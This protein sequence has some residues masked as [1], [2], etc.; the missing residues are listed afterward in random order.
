V[1]FIICIIIY[2]IPASINSQIIKGLWKGSFEVN[3]EVKKKVSINKYNF[4]V[5]INQINNKELIGVTYSY[6]T[7]EYS[8]KA[9]FNGDFNLVNKTATIRESI[10]SDVEKNDNS[11]VCKMV[12]VLKYSK[13]GNKELLTGVFTSFNQKNNKFCYA[14]K[15]YLEKVTETFFPKELFIKSLP[16][17]KTTQLSKNTIS[18]IVF[19]KIDKI[20]IKIKDSVVG[21]IKVLNTNLNPKI[22]ALEY[23]LP[24]EYNDRQNKLVEKLI[25]NEKDVT[26]SFFDN[27]IIDNDSISVFVNGQ[28]LINKKMINYTP[29]ILSLHL[30]IENP[31]IEIIAVAE[32]LGVYPPNT[33]L[34]ILSLLNKRFEVPISTDF[35]TNAKVIIEYDANKEILIQHY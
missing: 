34:M 30:T 7:K 8:A 19:K 2:L 10:I 33:A 4:E 31:I 5:Q 21:T 13:N 26:V 1:K 29:I 28:L 14:G 12:C 11:D 20:S 32:N 24:K 35:K 9:T 27:G 6:K 3:Q 15:V 18:D 23:N 16:K 25:I 22:I 17:L